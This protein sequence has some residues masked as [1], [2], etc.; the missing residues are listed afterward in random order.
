MNT[1][2]TAFH[3]KRVYIEKTGTPIPPCTKQKTHTFIRLAHKC[4]RCGLRCGLRM[5]RCSYSYQV[6]N[7]MNFAVLF[8]ACACCGAILRLYCSYNVLI[9]YRPC[10]VI[11]DGDVWFVA[12]DVC[13]VLGIQRTNDATCGLDDDEKVTEKIRTPKRV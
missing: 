8:G 6:Q 3:S 2:V 5:R 10:T 11:I 9:N 1:Q 13:D 4:L 7:F 12:K